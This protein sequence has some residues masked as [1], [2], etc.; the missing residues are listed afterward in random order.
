MYV[1]YDVYY[2]SLVFYYFDYVFYDVVD[3]GLNDGDV[4]ECFNEYYVRK[5]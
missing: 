4:V 3:C 2:F 5:F 1:M